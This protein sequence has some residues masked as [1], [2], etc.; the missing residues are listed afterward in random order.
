MCILSL[1]AGVAGCT[2]TG[3]G[4]GAEEPAAGSLGGA[5]LADDTC[6]ANLVCGADNICV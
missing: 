3:G 2:P 5:C 6:D 1:V 4:G